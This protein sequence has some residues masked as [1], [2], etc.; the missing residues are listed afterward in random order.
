ML[1]LEINTT[2]DEWDILLKIAFLTIAAKSEDIENEKD[3]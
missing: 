2:H 1:L 3:N